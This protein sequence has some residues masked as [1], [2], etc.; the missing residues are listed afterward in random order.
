MAIHED[1]AGDTYLYGAIKNTTG[2][3]TYPLVRFDHSNVKV[4]LELPAWTWSAAIVH[5]TFYYAGNGAFGSKIYMVRNIH[6]ANPELVQT[7]SVDLLTSLFQGSMADIAGMTEEQGVA[8]FDDDEVDASY[9]VGVD[10]AMENLVV[11]HINDA[12]GLVDKSGPA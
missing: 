2:T 11:M 8:V 3:T 9:L 5:N 7:G 4:V 10:R 1:P 12:D 6:T